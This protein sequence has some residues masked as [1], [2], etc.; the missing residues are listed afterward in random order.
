MDIIR[1]FNLLVEASFREKHS[2]KE[3]ADFLN[4]APK[5]LANLFKKLGSNTPLQFIQNRL[6]LEAHRLLKYSDKS[7]SDI[8]YEL[9]FS[10]IQAFSRFFKNQEGV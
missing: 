10:D 3:Y 4:K 5:S 6:L 2:V 1:R 9:G 8:G 7:I